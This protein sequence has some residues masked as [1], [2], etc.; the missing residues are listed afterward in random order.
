[1][2]YQ[3]LLTC[4]LYVMKNTNLT[5]NTLFINTV[6]LEETKWTKCNKEAVARHQSEAKTSPNHS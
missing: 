6:S 1:M 5:N 3:P 2:Q 4:N